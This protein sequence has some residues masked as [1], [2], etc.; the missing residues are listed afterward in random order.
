[1]KAG[2]ALKATSRVLR[3]ARNEAKRLPILTARRLRS[4]VGVRDL[5][6]R[7]V[8]G[9]T[10]PAL[11]LSGHD[12]AVIH[13]C[14][15]ADADATVD[16]RAATIVR[17]AAGKAERAASFRRAA[18]L[19]ADAA[20]IRRAGA[21]IEILPAAIGNEAALHAECRARL[22]HALALI[23]RVAQVRARA[24]SAVE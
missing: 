22:W 19:S 14:G 4:A 20:V 18:A 16:R 12:A 21:A 23:V 7:V 17:A 15:V 1:V 11:T 6:D 10:E 9:L 8:T 13:A 2:A 24:I 3:R 5:E